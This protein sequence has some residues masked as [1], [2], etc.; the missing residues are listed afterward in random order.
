[1]KVLSIIIGKLTIMV[2]KIVHK[3]SSL[4]GKL[5][6]KI[7]Y[8]LLSKF[9]FPKTRIMVTGSSGKGSTSKL[10]CDVLK[11]NGYSVCFNYEGANLKHGVTTACLKNCNLFGKIKKDIL[12]LEVDERYTKEVFKDINPNYLI[13]TNLTKDQPP[14]Q[15]N[16]DVILQEIQKNLP[17]KTTIIATIDEPYLRHF[18]LDMSN[19]NIHFGILKNKYSYKKQL[20]ENLNTYYCLKCGTRLEY[21]YYN[22]ETLGKYKCPNCDF[23][24]HK[25]DVIGTDLDLE[26]GTIKINDKE[27]SIGGDMLFNAYNTLA[28]YTLLKELG[29]NEDNIIESINNHNHNKNIEFIKNNKLYKALNCKAEN[30]TTYNASVY[31]IY[32]DK[33]LKDVII[34]WKEISRRYNHFDVSWLYDIEFE[35]LNNEHLNK[36]YAVGIDKENIKKRLLLA[37]IP[38]E[39]IITADTLEEIKDN[40]NNSDASVIYGILNFDYMEPFKTT[41]KEDNND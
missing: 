31:K 21:E 29:L 28:S 14:R 4:P 13:V 39:N 9:K 26:K 38:E 32:L 34:G 33:N 12:L 37:G 30:A 8:H 22:F 5:A 1:M 3:G 23:A 10:I 15:Y 36:I 2:G 35:L 20:F 24:W 6:L 17:K 16:V 19:K 41:F 25:P 27:V 18:E 11:D 7:D 40:V